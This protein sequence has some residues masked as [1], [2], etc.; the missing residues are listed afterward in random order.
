MASTT[1]G[2][3]GE[4]AD[5]LATSPD[6]RIFRRELRRL[7]PEGRTWERANGGQHNNVSLRLRDALRAFE[8]EGWVA[9]DEEAVVILD[10]A[11]LWLFANDP[12]GVQ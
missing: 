8:R 6:D 9:R 5:F 10:R 11:A 4:V 7:L 3:A 12:A 1:R 2:V